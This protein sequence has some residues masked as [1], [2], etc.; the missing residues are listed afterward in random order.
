M[1]PSSLGVVSPNE[2]ALCYGRLRAA[3]MGWKGLTMWGRR[4]DATQVAGLSTTRRFMPFVS[5]GRNASVVYYKTEIE[6]DAALAFLEEQNRDR[7]PEQRVTLFHLYLRAVSMALHERPGVNRFVSG[8]RVWQRDGVYITY[9]AKQDLID[10]APVLTIKRPFARDEGLVEMVDGLL[11]ELLA[12]R[13]GKESTADKEVNL[14]VRLPVPVLRVGLGALR[15][16]DR[17]GL[18]PRSMIETD[19]MFTSIFVANLGSVGLEAAYH[20]LWEYGTCSIFA[21]LG[22]IRERP[23]GTRTADVKYSYDERVADGLYA[24]ITLSS[25]RDRLQDPAALL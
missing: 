17:L 10:G 16:V 18:L 21:T 1:A 12:R 24:A 11:E 2:S 23:D 19:P 5:P 20:H 4:A 22:R 3:S 9:S 7:S 14:A 13:R 8:G 6:V 25:I 15:F